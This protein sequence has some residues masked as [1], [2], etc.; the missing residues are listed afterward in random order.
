MA[1]VVDDGLWMNSMAV[2]HNAGHWEFF[3]WNNRR[4]ERRPLNFPKGRR[5][6]RDTSLVISFKLIIKFGFFIPKILFKSKSP[7]MEQK[8]RD[9]AQKSA[10]YIC[11]SNYCDLMFSVAI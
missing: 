4:C 1:V 9:K 3:K 6:Q 8:Q 5:S 7:N 2:I 11:S 10:N